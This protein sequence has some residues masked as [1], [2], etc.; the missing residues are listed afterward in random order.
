M[1]D[2]FLV[3]APRV[4]GV[5]MNVDYRLGRGTL[6]QSHCGGGGGRGG[7]KKFA[8]GTCGHAQSVAENAALGQFS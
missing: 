3:R 8:A 7:E 1:R 4:V 6:C 2:E 5:L